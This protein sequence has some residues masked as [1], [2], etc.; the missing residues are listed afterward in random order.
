MGAAAGGHRHRR[1]GVEC[2]RTRYREGAMNMASP[3]PA[4]SRA[5]DAYRAAP[6][7]WGIGTR[8]LTR[9]DEAML[10]HLRESKEAAQ[11][12]AEWA[13]SLAFSARQGIARASIPRPSATRQGSVS[14]PT[15]M[16]SVRQS[17]CSP[18]SSTVWRT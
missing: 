5:I 2:R 18:R 15:R 14:A 9:G 11:A 10:D 8:H 7:V 3:V 16:L 6:Y 13:R 1:T 17:F 4:L 12:F